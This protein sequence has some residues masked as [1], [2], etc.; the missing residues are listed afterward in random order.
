MLAC[1][2]RQITARFF[3]FFRQRS[4]TYVSPMCK[5]AIRT[6]KFSATRVGGRSSAVEA[7]SDVCRVMMSGAHGAK[8]RSTSTTLYN[9]RTR[10]K[11]GESERS[12]VIGAAFRRR[13]LPSESR[14][15]PK[16]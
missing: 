1:Y 9:L 11:I 5:R 12:D 10:F 4:A 7:S 16:H 3:K 8:L 2:A 14:S 15:K 13:G 6:Q